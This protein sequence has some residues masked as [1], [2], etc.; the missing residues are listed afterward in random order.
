MM[1]T[2]VGREG[3]ARGHDAVL[4]A[5]R[6][7]GR[8]L[9]RLRPGDRRRQPRLASSPSCCRSSSAGTARPA[10]RAS[11]AA[12]RYDAASRHLHADLVAE[13]PAH[14][15][16]AGQ[17]AVRHPGRA[18]PARRRRRASCAQRRCT[19]STQAERDAARFPGLQARARAFDP[20]RLQR[21]G[22]PGIRL[23]RRAA[24]RRCWRTTPTPSTAGKPASAWRSTAR[25]ASSQ[26]ARRLASIRLDAPY[27]EA[28][29]TRAAPPH[30][31]RRL[32]GTGAHAA[33]RNLHR[34]AARR[35]RSAAHP[36]RARSHARAAGRRPCSPTGSGPTKRTSENGAYQPDPVSSGRRALAGLA[37]THLCLAARAQRRHRCGRARRC[38]RFKDAGNM[39]DRFNALAALVTRGH[40]LAAQAL[41]RF[42]AHVQGRGAG[43]RQMVRAAGRRARPR[44]QRPAARSSS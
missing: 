8:D 9:R 37:L 23:Q 12:R 18:G 1:Q 25:S 4:R 6:R 39:T 41:Q 15:G 29:R 33:G 31:R 40:A 3:F 27:I 35:G 24:A 21:A 20:A 28:M 10:R 11:T 22:D 36:R 30:A 2:L 26:P 38:Q 32:Q 44:R 16:P 42:H 19:C 14:A 34:R 7:P 43:A 13:L 5:P 17:G